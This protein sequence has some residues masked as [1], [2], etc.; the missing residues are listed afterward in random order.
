[1][2]RYVLVLVLILIIHPGTSL[3]SQ[4][5]SQQIL[6]PVAGVTSTGSINYSQTIG[7]TAVE[8]ISSSDFTFT[9]G[10]QQPGITLTLGN[11]PAGNGVDV[12]PNPAT[13]IVTI[14]FF[15]ENP[16]DFRIDILN[17]A[18]TI[19]YTE[20]VSFSDKYYVEKVIPVSQLN[21]GMYFVRVFSKDGV[22]NRSFK[23][24]KM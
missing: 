1:M 22:I 7:E 24:E 3:Y 5:L 15:G 9:Q 2:S 18:G 16:R 8:I 10:F 13:D 6:V 23:I 20:N 12:Y 21:K 4:E 11:P 14:K 19:V 17:I